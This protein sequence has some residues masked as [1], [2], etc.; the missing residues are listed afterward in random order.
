MKKTSDLT[1]ISKNGK[2]LYATPSEDKEKW[3]KKEL[4]ELV[5]LA[6]YEDLEKQ[7]RFV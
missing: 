6:L 3:P 5:K 4:E 2:E 1:R 7:S